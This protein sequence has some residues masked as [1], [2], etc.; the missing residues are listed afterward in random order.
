LL[1]YGLL[2]I[3]FAGEI[4]D[5]VVGV[6]LHQGGG[7]C[8]LGDPTQRVVGKRGRMTARIN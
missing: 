1:S 5:R 6:A 8:G 2:A 7:E 3:G 4:A